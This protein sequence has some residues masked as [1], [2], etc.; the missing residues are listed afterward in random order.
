MTSLTAEQ[1]LA[2]AQYFPLLR[3]QGP[4]FHYLDNAA[5]THKP[6]AVIEA[7][8]RCYRESYGPVHR[9]LYPLAEQASQGYEQ[10]R[11][12]LAQFLDAPAGSELVFTAS[13]T[14]SINLVAQG[15]AAP[16][17]KPGDEIWVSRLEHHANYL[18]WQAVCNDTG[19]HL[20][21]IEL[22][23][24]GQLDIDGAN[25]LFGR[26][27]A[28]I[29]ISLVSNVLGTRQPVAELVARAHRHNIPVLVDACQAMAY[30][31]VSVR[32]LDCDFLAFSAHKM[33]GPTGIG[34][35]YGTAAMM[36]NIEPQTLG[37]GM[38]DWVG[39]RHSHWSDLP[40]RLEA[41][42]PNLAGA[43]GF[44]AA[45]D[46][47]QQ[48][49]AELFQRQV[50]RLVGQTLDRL[51]ALSGVRCFAPE[52]ARHGAGILSFEVDGVHP[53]DVGQIAGEKGVAVRAGHH[54]CQPLMQYFGVA[55]TVRVSFAPYNTEADVDA[56]VEA[57]R[58]AQRLF[59][60]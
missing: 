29:A 53:H 35:L 42:S 15:W 4:A 24:D 28:L 60:E 37:G 18:P 54:C 30:G 22:R 40:A 20:R 7:M 31:D 3:S 34:A 2:F 48:F 27:T 25:G 59:A 5:T 13:A 8:S 49:P 57:V 58:A 52:A 16:R 41:G 56:L 36:K 47:I 21:V 23:P 43:L 32:E 17:L 46:F 50:Q 45:A 6:D 51:Q 11:Q 1:D 9:G 26:Q 55:A 33:Y 44:A 14:A 39:E 38:V 19:A 12:R 10:A